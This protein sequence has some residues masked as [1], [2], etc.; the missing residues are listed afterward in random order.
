M[1]ETEVK[2][3]RKLE[4]EEIRRDFP[5][6]GREVHGRPLVYFDN[7]ATTQKPKR[8]I[9]TIER[10][11]SLENANIH[12]GVHYLS[13]QATTA[14]E[15]ARK[16]VANFIGAASDREIIF[17]KGT[18]DSINLVAF[19]FGESLKEGDEILISH[20]EHHSNIV[21]W[22]MLCERK[23]CVLKVIPMN[24]RGEL[25]QEEFEKL[26]ST[27]TKLLAL[28][29]VSNSLGIVNP[30]RE[31]IRKARDYGA[32]VLIDGA[33]SVQHTTIDVVDLDC[34]FYVF[35]GHKIYGP[36][37]VGVLYGKESVLDA[38]TP[39]QGGGDMI[40]TVRF[41]KTTYNELPFKFE[42]GTPNIVGGIGLGAALDYL[43]EFDM[44]EIEA[45]EA[46]VSAYLGACLK[47]IDGVRIYGESEQ[48]LGVQ[49]FLVE[50]IH[51][52][53]LGTI[54][55]QQGVAVRTG[56]HC[57]QPIMDFYQIPGT[58]R[59]SFAMYNKKEEVDV[60]MNAL[61]RAVKML[62]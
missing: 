45:H 15:E 46:S 17:T 20:L 33:Q 54:L 26:L 16:K 11:Y 28:S 32:R 25:I 40:K 9:D 41:E 23:G 34:D 29:H 4:L 49:S 44:H 55:D 19:S 27:R 37:G 10:Y 39:Y 13:Q 7:G 50:G 5:L 31:M 6:L 14:Y 22:Q 60:F 58:V 61:E 43:S 56:H 36:T 21:P 53:D 52:F 2:G 24:D 62:K 30:V 1:L 3:K 42:A 51:P 35:S 12:R 47:E 18:T 59:A 38:M 8:V 57:T 48:K